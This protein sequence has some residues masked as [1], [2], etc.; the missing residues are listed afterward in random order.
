MTF[1]AS[2]V[3]KVWCVQSTIKYPIEGEVAVF[4]TTVIY[5]YLEY[6]VV[7]LFSIAQRISGAPRNIMW[8]STTHS[9]T[10]NTH[11]S[12]LGLHFKLIIYLMEQFRP[13]NVIFIGLF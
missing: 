6:T 13:E 1:H 12:L 3:L 4:I 11:L 10:K 9:S 5:F 2:P 7:H 8:T